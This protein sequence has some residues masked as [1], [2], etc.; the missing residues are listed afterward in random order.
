[1]FFRKLL[2]NEKEISDKKVGSSSFILTNKRLIKIKKGLGSKS[3]IE[4]PIRN[5]DALNILGV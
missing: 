4:I 5:I 3:I 1:M 2:L